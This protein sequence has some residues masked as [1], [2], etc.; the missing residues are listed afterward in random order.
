[1]YKRKFRKTID[2]IVYEVDCALVTVKAGADIDIGT[3]DS[4]SGDQNSAT[5]ANQAL[6]LLL[7]SRRMLWRTGL[8]RLTTSSIPSD[9][10]PPHSTRSPI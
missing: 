8:L 4:Q 6:T 1:M 2:D 3:V 7:R 10:N 5:D 9:S